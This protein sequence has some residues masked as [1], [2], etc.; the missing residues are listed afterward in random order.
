MSKEL[1][2]HLHETE[3]MLRVLVTAVNE[4]LESITNEIEMEELN[5]EDMPSWTELIKRVEPQTINDKVDGL[6]FALVQLVKRRIK[7]DYSGNESGKN[8]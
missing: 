4:L 8:E 6:Y 5:D 1:H 2:E 3:K 7:Q